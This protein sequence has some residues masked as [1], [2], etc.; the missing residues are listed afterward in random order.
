MPCASL[1]LL[2][3]HRI[4]SRLS[5]QNKNSL[6]VSSSPPAIPWQHSFPQC[7]SPDSFS[8]PVFLFISH[9]HASHRASRA[10]SPLS[11]HLAPVA[12]HGMCLADGGSV[13]TALH[14]AGAASA[15]TFPPVHHSPAAAPMH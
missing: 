15:S 14:S 12:P 5:K 2:L 1:C 10:L 6:A 4:S 8:A 3:G 13:L 7:L 9:L 11:L